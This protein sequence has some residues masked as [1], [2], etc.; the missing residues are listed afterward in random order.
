[1]PTTDD[2]GLRARDRLLLRGL[3]FLHKNG[4]RLVN[5]ARVADMLRQKGITVGQVGWTKAAVAALRG[6]RTSHGVGQAAP[7][8]RALDLT[9]NRCSTVAH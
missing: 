1:M 4:V 9:L 7:A 8:N 5:P 6:R 2:T 3:G